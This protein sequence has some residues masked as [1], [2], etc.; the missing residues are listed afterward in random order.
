MP[1]IQTPHGD[2]ALSFA[3]FIR[4]TR[5]RAILHVQRARGEE[6]KYA[7]GVQAR[8]VFSETNKR[9]HLE[10]HAPTWPKA[11]TTTIPKQFYRLLNDTTTTT[12]TT[13]KESTQS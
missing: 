12:T 6:E 5:R 4:I 3:D 13:T 9:W 11:Y 8:L 1:L 10:V 7:P 2:L